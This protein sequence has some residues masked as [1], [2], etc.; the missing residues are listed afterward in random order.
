MLIF[1]FK[2]CESFTT[3]FEF[4]AQMKEVIDECKKSEVKFYWQHL[5]KI[6]LVY[7]DFEA[8]KPIQIDQL[9]PI[10][11]EEIRNFCSTAAVKE[12]FMKK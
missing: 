1:M 6:F 11:I 3:L 2:D 5:K 12:Y 9:F 10:L 8:T 7:S 4:F